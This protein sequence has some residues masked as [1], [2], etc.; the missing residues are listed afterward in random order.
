M[1]VLVAAFIVS[2]LYS[3]MI[4]KPVLSISRISEKMSV[5]QLD[6][7]ADEQRTDELGI[8]GNSLNTLSR[9]LSAALSD[10]QSAN[11]KLEADIEHEKELEQARTNF[12]SAVSP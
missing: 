11:K 12:F 6:W 3:R 8:L 5:L 1:I 4:T 2:W 9:N 7:Q 10:L